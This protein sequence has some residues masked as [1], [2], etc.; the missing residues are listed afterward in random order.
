MQIIRCIMAAAFLWASSAQ[1]ALVS[2]TADTGWFAVA[3]EGVVI[4]E[5]G[6]M[7]LVYDT[8]V[9]DSDPSSTY[10]RYDGAI[11]SFVMT[12]TQQNRPDLFFTLAPGPNSLKVGYPNG[13]KFFTI[14]LTAM[15]QSGAYGLVPVV[16]NGY[17]A[18]SLG[19]DDLMPDAAYWN[20][21]IVAAAGSSVGPAQETDWGWNFRAVTLVPT[22]GT[23][24]LLFG[25]VAPLVAGGLLRRRVAR[26]RGTSH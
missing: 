7:N 23:V 14:R 19:L 9:P 26:N 20:S 12:V 8:S 2:V 1:A 11:V 13:N 16:L 10:G 21:G 22:T 25:G 6:T 17:R 5:Y 18:A 24:A 15:D 4:P 3:F